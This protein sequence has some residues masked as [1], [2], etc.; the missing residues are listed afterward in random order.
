MMATATGQGPGLLHGSADHVRPPAG[1]AGPGGQR[2]QEHLVPCPPR[3]R[4]DEAKRAGG[5]E[6]GEVG[7]NALILAQR[8]HTHEAEAATA[9]VVS[10]FLYAI[11]LPLWLVV[12]QAV[13]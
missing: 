10:T 4:G 9:I 3:E 6:I 11:T 7:A 5:P 12:L 1:I 13:A 8:Y 2:A